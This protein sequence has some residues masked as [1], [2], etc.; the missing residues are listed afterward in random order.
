M[1]DA[2]GQ[3]EPSANSNTKFLLIWA[4]AP[5]I[6]HSDSLVNSAHTGQGEVD[7]SANKQA[8]Q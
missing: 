8:L 4:I 6:K 1:E 2:V 5:S 3:T 7:N